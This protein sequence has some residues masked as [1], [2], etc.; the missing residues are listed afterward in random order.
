MG[1]L[2][3]RS[4]TPQVD[5]VHHVVD[6][7]RRLPT[8]PEVPQALSRLRSGGFRLATLTNSMLDA[9]KAQLAHAQLADLFDGVF[10]ADEVHALRPAAPP[11]RTVADRCGVPIG[12]LWLV[13]AHAWDVTGAMAAGL[14]IRSPVSARHRCALVSDPG[15]D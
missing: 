3:L 2:R 8:H 4:A 5:D 10:S 9:A 15:T 6:A 13:A 14:W 1:V 11:Y 12:D 7:M